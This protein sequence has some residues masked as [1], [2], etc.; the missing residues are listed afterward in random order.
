MECKELA[1]V[2]RYGLLKERMAALLTDGIRASLMEIYGYDTQVLEFIDM[3]HTPKNILLRG[4][5]SNGMRKKKISI[6]DVENMMD[7]LHTKQ[8]LAELLK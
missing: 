8:T 5:Q 1:P 4:V 2:M 6:A 3:S 7:M